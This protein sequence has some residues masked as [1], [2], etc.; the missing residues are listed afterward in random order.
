[1]NVFVSEVCY[2]QMFGSVKGSS[3]RRQ[4]D[5]NRLVA[6]LQA[7]RTRED[8]QVKGLGTK[9]YRSMGGRDV[10]GVDL[11]N[12]L[13]AERVVF[14]FVEPE[15]A[16]ARLR[17]AR[18]GQAG[19]SETVLLWRCCE[20]DSQHRGALQVAEAS[21]RGEV[22]DIS[23]TLPDTAVAELGR[24]EAGEVPWRTYA[25]G[26]LERYGR[27]RTPVLTEDKFRI[28][29]DFLR[30]PAPML[31]TGAAGSGKT[32]LG[33]RI[34]H[35]FVRAR[36]ELGGAAGKGAPRVLYVACS[37]RLLAEA[38]T[39]FADDVAPSCDFLTFDAL[40]KTLSNDAG[41]RFSDERTFSAFV[42]ALRARPA[43]S[44]PDRARMLRLVDECGEDCAYA[45]VYGAIAGGMGQGWDRF[46]TEATTAATVAAPT[47]SASPTGRACP[48]LLDEASYLALPDEGCGFTGDARRT[49]YGLACAF[50]R[51][52]RAAG[53]ADRNACAAGLVDGG[54]GAGSYDLVVADECQD[55]TEV[56]VEL[57]ARLAKDPCRLFLTGDVNQVLSPASFSARRMLRMG[58]GVRLER[59][60][61]NF[62]N[63][64][65][66]CEAAN[67][68]S[69]I[70]S[71]S[72]RLPARRA[73]EAAPERAFNRSSG[74]TMWCICD[75]EET[76][77][78]IADGAANIALVCDASAYP[79]LR[80][81][82]PNVFTVDQVKGME[83]DNVVLYGVLAARAARFDA[84]LS[85]GPKDASL[86]RPL[87][88]LYVGL[89][90]SR[91]SLL[92]VEPRGG[93]MLARLVTLDPRLE[94]VA[95]PLE[96]DFDLDTSPAGYLRAGLALKE[97]GNYA[98]ARANFERA[99]AASARSAGSVRP[100]QSG[101]PGYG[102]H[103]GQAAA[104]PVEAPLTRA[105]EDQARRQSRI[106]AIYQECSE[107]RASEEE[108]V[109]AFEGEGFYEEA[110]PHARDALD[111]RR[112][113][114][115]RLAA[116]RGLDGASYSSDDRV[117]AFEGALARY[118]LDLDDL[119]GVTEAYDD[120]LDW[121]LCQRLDDLELLAMETEA[122]VARVN[123]GLRGVAELW[124][125]VSLRQ[126]AEGSPPGANGAADGAV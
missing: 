48:G 8:L 55:L 76:L 33:F 20:H 3:T 114:L 51:W 30:S 9:K 97:Q 115:L 14:S 44:G 7:A 45:E 116:D 124:R 72:P 113:A 1:M 5:F 60:C 98:S 99:L 92:I 41:L 75:D 108:L 59:L 25:P 47:G 46:S 125:A 107:R 54:V 70:R 101:R 63:P 68:V 104:G 22:P 34:V 11:N 121:Y 26:D 89:T 36:L 65:S 96:V 49:V 28:V 6:R 88:A 61:G 31:V 19:E 112:C 4:D 15:D 39:H 82:S 52:V 94:K 102:G 100:G 50:M 10:Y 105:E 67:A 13:T 83:F 17:F 119:R 32:E 81:L 123:E 126:G 106:C 18:Y 95:D 84:V 2:R 62:R 64:E 24:V 40:L 85:A 86:H 69:E 43:M 87:N 78:A 16:E 77:C 122:S 56:Q 12:G 79:R 42:A 23:W 120:L 35:D 80:C 91:G 37:Q 90:R 73:G 103:P 57:L 58:R 117:A 71:S 27:P 118:G 38:E 53:L 109:L 74:R 29:G 111:L 93:Q 110:L 66:V 21:A